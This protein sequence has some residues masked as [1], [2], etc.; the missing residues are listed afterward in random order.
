MSMWIVA[1]L[2]QSRGTA[3]DA[4]NRLRTEGVPDD[5]LAVRTLK[6]TGPIPDTVK[7]ELAFLAVDPM[8][9]GDVRH[10][11]VDHIHNGETLV[12]IGA[13]S[14]SE[15]EFAQDTLEQ[16]GPIAIEVFNA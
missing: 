4:R 3:E 1:G 9:L 5:K 7:A 2:F 13:V 12:L 16:Y 15:S 14:P 8:V 11:F 6:E 10:K